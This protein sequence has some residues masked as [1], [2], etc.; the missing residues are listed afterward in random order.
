MH[1][2][3]RAKKTM[4]TVKE[5][6]KSLGAA[7]APRDAVIEEFARNLQAAMNARGWNQS[8]LARAATLH[9]G[10]DGEVQR[11]NVSK[12]IN[13]KTLPSPKKLSAI[14]AALGIPKDELYPTT[15][16]LKPSIHTPP[17][18]VHDVGDGMA[19]VRVNQAVK[20]DIALK[21][22]DLLKKGDDED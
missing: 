13:G 5:D 10:G 16:V 15:S 22:L 19:W 3:P 18:G 8:D 11:D 21:I 1:D 4:L 6:P 9:M 2:T 17:V 14:A 12:Y 7:A 20:W